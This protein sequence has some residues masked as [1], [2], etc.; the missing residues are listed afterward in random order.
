M[1]TEKLSHFSTVRFLSSH[2]KKTYKTRQLTQISRKMLQYLKTIK[3]F[4]KNDQNNKFYLQ[5]YF[6]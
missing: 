6:S 2:N 4:L 1:Y 5:L 3:K